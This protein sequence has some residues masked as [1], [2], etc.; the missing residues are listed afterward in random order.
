M[1]YWT[2]DCTQNSSNYWL[3]SPDI[4]IVIDTWHLIGHLILL[5]TALITVHLYLHIN[6]VLLQYIF[7]IVSLLFMHVHLPLYSYTFTRSSN[8]LDLHIQICGYLLLVR[9][10]ERITYITRSL[11]FTLFDPGY[12]SCPPFIF[13]HF[14]DSLYIG[15]ST[16]S[17]LYSSVIMCAH[18]LLL[19]WY[20]FIIVII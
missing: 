18:L 16:S 20:W 6:A 3:Y 9:Y 4:L 19:Q 17:F 15:L 5:L 10:L 7:F 2:P 12:S 8:S 13:S 1:L 11:M 14:L